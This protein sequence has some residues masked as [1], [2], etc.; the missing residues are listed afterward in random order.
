MKKEYLE[1]T[2]YINLFLITGKNNFERYL[3]EYKDKKNLSFLQLGVYKG[4]ASIWLIENILT[5]K[6]STLTDVDTWLGNEDSI[7]QELDWNNIENIYDN[8]I[9]N[10]KNIKKEK[11]DSIKFF[12]N[13]KDKKYDFIYVDLDYRSG[14]ISKNCYLFW[15]LL[16]NG[17]TMAINNYGWIADPNDLFSSIKIGVDLFVN[18]VSENCTLLERSYQIWIKKK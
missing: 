15:D 2:D 8:K 5:N 12:E 1:D 16:K 17:G 7:D 6:N 13:N 18:D 10:Y 3:S 4:D 14:I 11:I 9:K